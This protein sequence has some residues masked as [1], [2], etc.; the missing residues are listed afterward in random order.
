M[1]HRIVAATIMVGLLTAPAFAFDIDH[2]GNYTEG[3]GD[4]AVTVCKNFTGTDD[5]RS[6]CTDWCSSYVAA[7]SGAKCECDDGACPED[8]TAP[9]AASA[10]AH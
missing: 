6:H 1:L 3:S 9:A 4:A 10:P 7:N 2:H 8:A 5:N